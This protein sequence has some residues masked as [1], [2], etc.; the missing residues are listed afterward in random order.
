MNPFYGGI[1]CFIFMMLKFSPKNMLIWRGLS[2]ISN[3]HL[4]LKKVKPSLNSLHPQYLGI[5]KCLQFGPWN[6]RIVSLHH[7]K[8]SIPEGNLVGRG[9]SRGQRGWIFQYLLSFCEVLTFSHRQFFYK[10]WIRIRIVKP[11]LPCWWWDVGGSYKWTGIGIDGWSTNND[12]HGFDHFHV[13]DRR[14]EYHYHVH[15]HRLLSMMHVERCAKS[16][17]TCIWELANLWLRDNILCTHVRR[18]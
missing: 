16:S 3:V 10:Q 11:I 15:H 17:N 12:C 8:G 14:H 7:N 9:K 2:K 1:P 13:C 6:P 4:N 5:L 18:Q